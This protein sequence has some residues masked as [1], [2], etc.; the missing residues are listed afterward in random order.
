MSRTGERNAKSRRAVRFL[1]L[2]LGLL[3]LGLAS[4]VVA[5]VDLELSAVAIDGFPMTGAEVDIVG[6]RSRS[7]RFRLCFS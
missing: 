6:R 3:T 5:Q 7:R 4:H 2:V 1:V